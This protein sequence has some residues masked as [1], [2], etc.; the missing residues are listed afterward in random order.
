M[1]VPIGGAT[2]PELNPNV[3]THTSPIND[4]SYPTPVKFNSYN[5]RT[6]NPA[7]SSSGG[8]YPGYFIICR[9]HTV[10]CFLCMFLSLMADGATALGFAILQCRS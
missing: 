5:A 7:I 2:T 4:L 10:I 9:L 3:N 8:Q 6:E 1:Y